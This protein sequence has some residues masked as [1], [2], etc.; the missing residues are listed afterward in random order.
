MS[1]PVLIVIGFVALL[2]IA[3]AIWAIREAGPFI[4]MILLCLA[5]GALVVVGLGAGKVI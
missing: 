1:I 4:G 2:L 5:I 3:G